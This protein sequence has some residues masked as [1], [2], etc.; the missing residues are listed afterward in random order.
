MHFSIKSASFKTTAGMYSHS[1]M[2]HLKLIGYAY[3]IQMNG[4]FLC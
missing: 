2:P 1:K 4:I 3:S